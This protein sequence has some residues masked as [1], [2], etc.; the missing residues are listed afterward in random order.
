MGLRHGL[1]GCIEL[2]EGADVSDAQEK[3]TA[4]GLPSAQDWIR[5]ATA[6]TLV[7]AFHLTLLKNA[8]SSLF[9]QSCVW[10]LKISDSLL[11]FS[12]Y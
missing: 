1:A 5:T 11:I 3:M 4:T 12:Y 8:F 10:F 6:N 2:K 9:S 7:S